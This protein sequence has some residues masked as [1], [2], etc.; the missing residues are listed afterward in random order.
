LV[1]V[2]AEEDVRFVKRKPELPAV[3]WVISSL[4]F[5][6]AAPTPILPVV[7]KSVAVVVERADTPE[8]FN[9]LLQEGSPAATVNI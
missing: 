8:I 7:V 6:L 1:V 2:V 3:P 5:G 9:E 4:L